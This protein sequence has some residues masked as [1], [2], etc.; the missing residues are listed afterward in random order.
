[1]AFITVAQFKGGVGKTTSAVHIAA[2]LQTLGSTLLIDGDPNR[3]ATAW[4]EQGGLP[5]DIVDEKQGAYQAR[6]TSML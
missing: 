2:Y 4:G 6:T 1:M 5:F 3:Q